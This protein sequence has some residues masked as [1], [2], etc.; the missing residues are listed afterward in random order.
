M[1]STLILLLSNHLQNVK[2][3]K[4]V[5]SCE[6]RGQYVCGYRDVTKISSCRVDITSRQGIKQLGISFGFIFLL[7]PYERSQGPHFI[8]AGG[9]PRDQALNDSYW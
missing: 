7:L 8:V 5:L 3:L 9:N 6:Y 2:P 4:Q 1:Y